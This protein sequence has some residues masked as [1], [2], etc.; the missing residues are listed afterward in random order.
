MAIFRPGPIAATISG[1]LGTS[2]FVQGMYGPYVRNRITRADK[3]SERQLEIRTRFRRV[4]NL[5]NELTDEQKLTWD[6]AGANER[7][8]NRL[9][10]PR[11]MKGN[12]LFFRLNMMAEP[13]D[14]GPYTTPPV[15]KTTDPYRDVV[16]TITLPNIYRVEFWTEFLPALFR[17][18][19]ATARPVSGVPVKPVKHWRLT[20][21]NS[22]Q[23]YP[24][25][26]KS[27]F[28]ATWGE[29]QIGEYVYC[30]IRG[31]SFIRTPSHWVEATAIVT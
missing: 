29:P 17:V 13:W 31:W 10:L 24:V 25:N 18:Q 8:V 16:F 21:T 22:S 20:L 3:L 23:P 4:K 26:F 2:N 11:P 27:E 6:A 30:R 9:G 19:I 28:L 5:W 15:L 7:Y 1:N 14:Y 12:T